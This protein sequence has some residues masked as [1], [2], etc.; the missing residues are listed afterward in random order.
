LHR[1]WIVANVKVEAVRQLRQPVAF[2]L[3]AYSTQSGNSFVPAMIEEAYQW[4]CDQR[5]I[6]FYYVASNKN[7]K[8]LEGLNF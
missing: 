4:A 7:P 5:L 6:K 2:M 3:Q 8:V 1:N